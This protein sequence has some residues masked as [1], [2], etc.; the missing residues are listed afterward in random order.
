MIPI[1]EEK[2]WT[3]EDYLELE[4][5]KRYEIIGGRLLMT[6]S[7]EFNHQLISARLEFLLMKFVE[8][9][10]L[11][12]VVHAPT[13]IV[14]DRDN[15][16]Q[17]DILFILKENK[18][19]IQKR[20]I[21]GPPD[22]VIEIV[23]PSSQYRDIY[24]KKGLYEKFRIK[25]FWLVNPYMKSVEVLILNEQGFYELF[26]EGYMEEGESKVIKSIVLKDF[27]IDLK[28]IFR[29]II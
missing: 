29:E 12:Y 2:K 9:K 3:Y 13:D 27:E 5:D 26:S 23:S 4:D 19:I 22:I 16:V 21:F 24:K 6:P 18:G 7:P 28:E 14:L 17:P 20:G 1:T 11:G 15:V 8:E 25:E 10:G